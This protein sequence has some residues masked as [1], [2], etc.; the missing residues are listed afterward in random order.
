M[1][2]Q[3]PLT[4]SYVKNTWLFSLAASWPNV[5]GQ[6]QNPPKCCHHLSLA[7]S[8]PPGP[9]ASCIHRLQFI[10]TLSTTPSKHSS[11][12]KQFSKSNANKTSR[13][14]QI[15]ETPR[16]ELTQ[17]PPE[18]LKCFRVASQTSPRRLQDAP[19]KCLPAPRAL[20][21]DA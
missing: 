1:N 9:G 15:S 2:D 16:P 6:H 11:Q 4:P 12:R 21:H 20:L 17:N 10:N 3:I 7:V 5:D 18:H 19:P 14:A 13:L 8:V